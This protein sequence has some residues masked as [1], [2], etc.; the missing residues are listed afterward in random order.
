[1]R[2]R[3]SRTIGASTA[4]NIRRSWRFQPWARVARYQASGGGSGCM[5][6][7]ELVGLAC[8]VARKPDSSARPSSSRIPAF[9]AATWSGV[10]RLPQRERVLALDAEP[11]VEHALGP[12]AVVGE[13]EQALRVLVEAADRVEAGAV[14]HEGGRDEL[15]DGRAAWRSGSSR[16]RRRACGAAT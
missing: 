8:V 14:G 5:S 2:T 16:S 9:R 10:E 11:R 3:T 13:Q 12:V 15:E 1:M 4:P 7:G 6:V